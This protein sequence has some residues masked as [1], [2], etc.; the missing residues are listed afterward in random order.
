VKKALASPKVQEVD[1]WNHSITGM[2]LEVWVSPY[3]L[4]LHHVITSIC[5]KKKL[6]PILFLPSLLLKVIQVAPFL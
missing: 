3:F 6:K 4:P 2:V 5:Y 1:L